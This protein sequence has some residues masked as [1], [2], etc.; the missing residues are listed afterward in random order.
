MMGKENNFH[1]LFLLGSVTPCSCLT[2]TLVPNAISLAAK[3]NNDID[4]Y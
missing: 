2:K 4:Q 1:F 3:K